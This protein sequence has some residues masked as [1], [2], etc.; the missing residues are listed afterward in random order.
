MIFVYYINL[1]KKWK[2]K[3]LKLEVKIPLMILL[4]YYYKNKSNLNDKRNLE[5]IKL[6]QK[7]I[8]LDLIS[9]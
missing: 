1:L 4:V 6:Y 7:E 8:E 2:I 3:I 5:V 9:D